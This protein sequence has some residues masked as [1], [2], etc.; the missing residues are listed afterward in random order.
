MTE[1][2]VDDLTRQRLDKWLWHARVVRTRAAAAELAKSG[3]VRV[4]GVRAQQA[5]KP[6]T[7]GDIIT[8][9]L[10]RSIRVLEVL[11]F[12]ER[13]GPYSEAATLYREIDSDGANQN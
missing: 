8:I 7:A 5:A 1:K 11:G 12:S 2:R 10:D 9:A 6:V 3:Y 13:R 4:N